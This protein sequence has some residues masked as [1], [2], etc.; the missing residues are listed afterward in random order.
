MSIQKYVSIVTDIIDGDNIPIIESQ[1]EL[2]NI[3]D[4]YNN[5]R[6]QFL[7][8]LIER[9]ILFD[10][11][12]NVVEYSEQTKNEIID[13][14]IEDINTQME[15]AMMIFIQENNAVELYIQYLNNLYIPRR[16]ISHSQE[17]DETYEDN[18]NL[19]LTKGEN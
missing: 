6:E 15:A 17:D 11:N 4:F 7:N 1:E 5:N 9:I 3:F 18:Q 13:Q 2:I 16:E 19:Q 12:G 10:D 8:L 14:L